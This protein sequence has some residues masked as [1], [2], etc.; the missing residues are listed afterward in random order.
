MSVCVL[1]VSHRASV[2]GCDSKRLLPLLPDFHHLTSDILFLWEISLYCH[3]LMEGCQLK[4]HFLSSVLSLLPSARHVTWMAANAE[5]HPPATVIGS[6]GR[7]S[8]N[9]TPSNSFPG[10]DVS[11]GREK[12]S[13]CLDS[14]WMLWAS[15]LPSVGTKQSRREGFREDAGSM[16][17]QLCSCDR[18]S[19]PSSFITVRSYPPTKVLLLFIPHSG[20][21]KVP[22]VKGLGTAAY[23]HGGKHGSS[24]NYCIRPPWVWVQVFHL[25]CLSLFV[26][27]MGKVGSGK[28]L[29]QVY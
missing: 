14:G 24:G 26:Y 12:A 5:P 29:S 3:I 6:R 2:V 28:W 21:F 27:K 9:Q 13:S 17:C 19:C 18:G 4:L 25:G 1:P 11:D 7:C 16:E 8:T 10:M 20:L 15:S 23:D 22:E